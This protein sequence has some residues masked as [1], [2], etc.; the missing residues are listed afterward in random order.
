M[1][2]QEILLIKKTFHSD[3]TITCETVHIGKLT[4]ISKQ[5]LQAFWGQQ[6]HYSRQFRGGVLM[7]QLGFLTR[8]G[9]SYTAKSAWWRWLLWPLLSGSLQ[10]NYA[11]TAMLAGHHVVVYFECLQYISSLVAKSLS[12]KDNSLWSLCLL[13]Q[14]PSAGLRCEPLWCLDESC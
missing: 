3:F 12:A 2:I 14:M 11:G 7:S 6:N 8:L 1:K 4:L 10:L 5:W 9:L 13:H